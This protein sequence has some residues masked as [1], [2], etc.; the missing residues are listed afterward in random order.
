M[1][2]PQGVRKIDDWATNNNVE[3][4]LYN[5]G[6]SSDAQDPEDRPTLRV[7]CRRFCPLPEDQLS[8]SWISKGRKIDFQLP[9]Y[10]IPDRQL[11]KIA[12][13]L[14]ELVAANFHTLLNELAYNQDEIITMSLAEAARHA[15]TVSREKHLGT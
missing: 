15:E 7:V 8:K 13:S 1:S 10:A 14:E 11:T 12:K 4:I 2:F 5:V 3:L 9:T 6:V